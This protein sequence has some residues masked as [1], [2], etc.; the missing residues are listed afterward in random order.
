MR[1]LLEIH[2]KSWEPSFWKVMDSF[3]LLAYASF[4][5]S[6]TFLLAWLY[7][8]IRRFIIL[9]QTKK[10]ISVNYGSSTSSWKPWWWV[11]FELIFPMRDICINSSLNTEF[12]KSSRSTKFKYILPWNISQMITKNVPISKRIVISYSIKWRIPLWSQWKLRH[13]MIRSSQWRQSHCRTNTSIRRKK[14]IQKSRTMI[15]TIW[16]LFL[17]YFCNYFCLKKLHLRCCIGLELNILTWSTKVLKVI[18]GNPYNLEKTWK[19]H[20]PRCPKSTFPK[21]FHTLSFLHLISNGLNRINI[22]SLT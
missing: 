17:F 5:A 20:P 18:G 15:I 16:D 22:N 12:T 2:Q 21:V 14:K 1:K 19:I 4:A 11:R 9:L 7:F 3:L 13:N 6:R 8:R 10:M